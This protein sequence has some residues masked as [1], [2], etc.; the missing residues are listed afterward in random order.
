MQH[1]KPTQYILK[2]RCPAASGIVAAI[3]GCLASNG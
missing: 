1:N 3:S 2:I